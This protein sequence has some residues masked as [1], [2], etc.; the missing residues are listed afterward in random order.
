[1]SRRVAAL[2]AHLGRA[3]DADEEGAG[4]PFAGATRPV[5]AVS[6]A[7]TAANDTPL[8]ADVGALPLPPVCEIEGLFPSFPQ[9]LADAK[10]TR[11][12]VYSYNIMGGRRLTVVQDPEL[13]EVVFSPHEMGMTPGIGD[14]V[15][16]EMAKLGE[17]ARGAPAPRARSR[18]RPA[19]A[20]ARQPTR[21]SAS[22]W[23]S[24][25]R[26]TPRC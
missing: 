4:C 2:A 13:Y 20:R 17:F 23:R 25:R 14:A 5:S 19:D 15:H 22:R 11:A 9:M 18:N 7:L 10:R 1:M 24:R 21:G 3:A 16:V 6:R 26:R 8:P 12:G